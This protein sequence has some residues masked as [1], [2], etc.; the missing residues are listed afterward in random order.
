LVPPNYFYPDIGAL[1]AFRDTLLIGGTFWVA[2]TDSIERVAKWVGGTYTSACGGPTGL[3]PSDPV[4]RELLIFP[5]PANERIRIEFPA[6]TI[7]EQLV[8]FD[9]TGRVVETWRIDRS[10]MDLD[11]SHLALGSYTVWTSEGQQA[12]LVLVR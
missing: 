10:T 9:A 4:V 5:N 3:T 11:L 2:G 12:R 8:L 6:S 7:G 1:G